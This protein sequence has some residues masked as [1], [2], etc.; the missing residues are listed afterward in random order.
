MVFIFIAILFKIS[1]VQLFLINIRTL[2][3]ISLV[4]DDLYQVLKYIEIKFCF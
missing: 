4:I 3:I 1:M 2:S